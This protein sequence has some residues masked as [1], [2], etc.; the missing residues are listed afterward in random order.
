MIDAQLLRELAAIAGDDYVLT[1]QGERLVYECDGFTLGRNLPEVVVL[2]GNSDEVA[3]II[4][5]LHARRIPFVPRGAGTGLSGGTMPPEGAVMLGLSRLNRIIEVDYRNR[6]AV[7][8][9]GVVNAHLSDFVAAAGFGFA[10]DP[11]SGAASTIGGNV[12][13]NAGG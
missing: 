7:V 4:R 6:C 10:P 13:E 1:A 5:L 11:S 12:A 3:R 9:S 8:E 2:P